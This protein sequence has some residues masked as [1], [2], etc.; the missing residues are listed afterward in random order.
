MEA[1]QTFSILFWITKTELIVIVY[2][3]KELSLKE[4]AENM[5]VAMTTIRVYRYNILKNYN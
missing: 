2:I 4:I 3:K 1:K 5:N